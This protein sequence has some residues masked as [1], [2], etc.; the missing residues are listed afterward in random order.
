[1]HGDRLL[2]A[3]IDKL[4]ASG[5]AWPQPDRDAWLSLMRSAFD[6]VYGRDGQAPPKQTPVE[7]PKI[8]LVGDD[9]PAAPVKDWHVDAGGV[10]RSP[11]GEEAP[12]E[13]VPRNTGFLDLRPGSDG[14]LDTVIW[15]DGT[16][17]ASHVRARGL[18]LILPPTAKA[19]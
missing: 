3:L 8:P 17:P 9:A 11:D 4:P 18:K 10:A 5:E 16:W 19:A 14:R 15:A 1:M 13:G 2:D 12:L 6:L 7:L